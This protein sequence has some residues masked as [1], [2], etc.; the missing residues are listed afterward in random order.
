[1]TWAIEVNGLS[2]RYRLGR[3]HAQRLD[4]LYEAVTDTARDLASR[5]S[6]GRVGRRRRP[7]SEDPRIEIQSEHLVLAESQFQDA[8]PGEFWALRNVSFRIDQGQRIGVI[9]RNGSGKSTLLKLLSRI[10]DP[11][12]GSFQ[13]RGRL[14][15]LLEVGTG[16]HPDLTGRENIFLNAQITG[17][18]AREIRG[19]FDEIVEFSELGRQIDTP[20][21]RYSSGMYMRLAFSVAAHIN[22]EI[23]VVDEVL[24]VGDA[25]FQRKCLAKMLEIG[26]S[27]RTLLFVSHDMEAV[28]QLC[29]RAIEL[30]HGEVVSFQPV[31]A[32]PPRDARPARASSEGSGLQPIDDAI[33]DYSL[34]RERRPER[35]W[36]PESAPTSATGALTLVGVSLGEGVADR[37]TPVTPS[38]A[39]TVR[40][41]VRRAPRVRRIGVRLHVATVS[42]RTLAVSAAVLEV[43]PGDETSVRLLAT[44]TPPFFNPG[45]FRMT[46][47]LFDADDR[48]EFCVAPDAV[49]VVVEGEPAPAYPAEPAAPLAAN[50]TWHAAPGPPPTDDHP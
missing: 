45:L 17:M 25:G 15:S 44:V 31:P 33:T 10:T 13:F 43:P 12:E 3:G 47:T 2:K 6:A 11:T 14:V 9:G 23:L 4:S 49:D 26:N 41:D 19:V 1:M 38:D 34:D 48:S 35:S 30:A 27:G 29:S 16:F 20:I 7:A 40:L 36:A 50:L 42:R 8:P 24:A 28:R 39:V 18:S 46:V 21:K 32:R 22:S 37:L 5:L